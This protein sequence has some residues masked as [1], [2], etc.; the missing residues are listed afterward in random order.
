M[1]FLGTAA[2]EGG[3][4]TTCNVCSSDSRELRRHLGFRD[5]RRA[6]PAVATDYGALK[7]RLADV[8]PDDR[9]S[10]EENGMLTSASRTP[11]ILYPELEYEE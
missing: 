4:R 5:W 6:N 8:Y 7:R 9:A 2:G 3:R 10:S 1:M 11:R